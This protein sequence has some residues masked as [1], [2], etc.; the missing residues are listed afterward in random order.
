[1]SNA[2]DIY[3]RSLYELAVA[4]GLEERIL[5]ESE[6]LLAIFSENPAY[7]TLLSEPSIPKRERLG[8]IDEAIGSSVHPYVSNFIKI[9]TERGMMREYAA[10]IRYYRTSY[11]ES[12]GI[13]EAVVTSAVALSRE[14]EDRLRVRLEQMSGKRVKIR[15]RVDESVLGGL[16]VELAGRQLDGTVQGRLTELRKKVEDT[17]L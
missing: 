2:G 10:C 17:V 13:A 15:T 1:M 14:E 16:R 11:N 3:G 12:H 7:I 4:D 9:L 6:T 8:L 5:T